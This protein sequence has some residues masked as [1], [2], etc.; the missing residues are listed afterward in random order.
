[1]LPLLMEHNRKAA[2]ARAAREA[3]PNEA[4]GDVPGGALAG[5]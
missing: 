3:K 5:S 1:V 4:P 2:E